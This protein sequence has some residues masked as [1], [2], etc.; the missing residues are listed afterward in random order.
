MNVSLCQVNQGGGCGGVWGGMG[1]IVRA[2]LRVLY[3]AFYS[4]FFSTIVMYNVMS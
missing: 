2:W 3:M 4:L 1:V